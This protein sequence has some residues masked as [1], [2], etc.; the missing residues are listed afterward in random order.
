M[1]NIIKAIHLV[2][3]QPYPT[4]QGIVYQETKQDGSAWS[5]PEEGLTWNNATYQKPAWVDIQSK[6]IDVDL[7]EIKDKKKLEIKALRQSNLC[8]LLLSK[9][10][11]ATLD[12]Y[13]KTT[14]EKNLF[15]SAFLIADGS[16]REWGC[17][18]LT[19][20]ERDEVNNGELI[21][22]D[23]MK[24][25]VSLTKAELLSLAQHY[26]IRSDLE[27]NQCDKRR[28]K[29]QC[30]TATSEVNAYDITTIEV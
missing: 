21:L 17:Y 20:A 4:M 13:V 30:F 23:L 11:D 14:P 19:T 25:S 5:N 26:E 9:G 27:F 1:S 18:K 16:S 22:T 28:K 29:V 8:K 3:N 15:Q 6:L 12:Y 10:V 24:D 7:Q 2:H